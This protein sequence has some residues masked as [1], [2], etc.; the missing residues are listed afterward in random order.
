MAVAQFLAL[1]L[2]QHCVWTTFPAGGG[3]R[4]RGAQLKAMGLMAGW[5]DIQILV[6]STAYDTSYPLSRFIG[7]ELKREK[8]GHVTQSQHDAHALIKNAGGA[9]YV[10]KALTEI[11]DIL[12]GMERLK[13][14]CQPIGAK[15]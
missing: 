3:G 11:Y 9:V 14:K 2:P 13:L 6:R 5:P 12:T 4:I 15:K 1:A 7:L 10:V 8:G